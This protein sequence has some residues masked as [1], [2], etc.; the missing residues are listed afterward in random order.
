MTR[1]DNSRLARA[2]VE[3]CARAEWNEVRALADPDLVY[4]EIGMNGVLV[5][6][7]A[8]IERWAEVA[9][10][11]SPVHAEIYEVS[12]QDDLTAVQV[13][14]RATRAPVAGDDGADDPDAGKTVVLPDIVIS[15]WQHGRLVT[16][17]HRV[18]IISVLSAAAGILAIAPT[19]SVERAPRDHGTE[20]TVP[21]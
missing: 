21:G 4:E 2:V 6:V 18:G 5:G 16:E 15:R 11:F 3:S 10:H 13:K 8:V 7:D 17:K 1:T 20:F 12:A 9:A 14:W 19:S